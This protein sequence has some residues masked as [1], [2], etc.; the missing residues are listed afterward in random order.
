[1]SSGERRVATQSERRAA[2]NVIRAVVLTGATPSTAVTVLRSGSI[3]LWAQGQPDNQA[4]GSPREPVLSAADR[5]QKLSFATNPFASASLEIVS[6]L[7]WP[8]SKLMEPVSTPLRSRLPPPSTASVYA[9]C[10][11]GPPKRPARTT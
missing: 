7:G 8:S 6:P 3:H 9:I 5:D 1:M 2:R 11:P 10:P 4:P